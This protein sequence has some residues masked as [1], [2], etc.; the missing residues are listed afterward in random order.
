[1]LL[2]QNGT[3]P[4]CHTFPATAKQLRS[5]SQ[6]AIQFSKTVSIWCKS[7][8][9]RTCWK[10]GGLKHF[11]CIIEIAAFFFRR[12]RV[13]IATKTLFC[14]VLVFS[15][16]ACKLLKSAPSHEFPEYCGHALMSCEMILG[17]CGSG[18]Q[19]DKH[20]DFFVSSST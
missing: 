5:K 17:S 1:M 4:A 19:R 14:D 2:L 16:L 9:L 6:S 12:L 20:L 11:E 13:D 15:G 7:Q 3:C 8:Q 18:D 10:L